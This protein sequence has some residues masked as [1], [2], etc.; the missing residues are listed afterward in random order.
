MKEA[1]S[2]N[3]EEEEGGGIGGGRGKDDGG[4]GEAKGASGKR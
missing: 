4:V 3:V 2:K 1:E